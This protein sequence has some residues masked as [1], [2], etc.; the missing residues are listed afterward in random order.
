MRYRFKT[1]ITGVPEVA[2]R[3]LRRILSVITFI[4]VHSLFATVGNTFVSLAIVRINSYAIWFVNKVA[5]FWNESENPV[6]GL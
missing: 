3:N 4:C 1:Y 2:L 5:I 6:K